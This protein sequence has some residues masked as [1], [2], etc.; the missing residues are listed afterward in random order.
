MENQRGKDKKISKNVI[1]PKL[2]SWSVGYLY[3]WGK[4]R[5]NR[6]NK[7]KYERKRKRNC[8]IWRKISAKNR[9]KSNFIRIPSLAPQFL[10]FSLSPTLKKIRGGEWMCSQ[11]IKK[12]RWVE[13]NFEKT[14]AIENENA[15]DTV[16]W[17]RWT[18]YFWASMRKNSEFLRQ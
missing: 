13:I 1:V 7:K 5:K 10:R 12:I 11:G 6:G 14:K 17:S 16:Y 8:K 3:C 18:W 15:F 9:K 4:N 2:Y